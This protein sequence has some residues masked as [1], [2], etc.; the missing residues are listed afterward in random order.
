MRT[1]TRRSARQAPWCTRRATTHSYPYCWRTKTPIIYRATPQWF[2]S[3]EKQGLRADTL[4]AIRTVKWVPD[5]G[6][7]RID[8]MIAGRP[9]W[10]ISRQRYWGV[11]ICFLTHRDSG[12]LHPDT[13][14]LIERAASAIETSGIQA[15]F[16]MSV[17]DALGPDGGDPAEWEKVTDVL[18]VWFDS[19]TTWSHVLQASDRYP[20][21]MYLEGSDQHRGWF[22]SSLLTSVR[23]REARPVPTGA[24]A[25][26]HGRC[27]GAQDVEVARQRHRP[28]EAHED[29][30]ARTSSGSGC[31]RRDYR[32]EMT[33]A[34]EILDRMSD[35]LP[36]HPE[37]RP[38]PASAIG[39]FDPATDA[40]PP[41]DMLALD[42]WAVDRDAR[43]PGEI[44]TAYER[45]QFHTVY[46]T[47]HNFCAVDMAAST[48]TS[49][50]I[51][52]TRC[53]AAS[54]GQAHPPRAPCS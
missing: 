47:L 9:D 8:G 54:R 1:W 45:Y 16:D 43:R 20:A 51:A 53:R 52:S 36:A 33:V 40:V 22:H 2:V 12:E 50:R 4:E 49:S 39:D 44:E 23:D 14:T 46:Q 41:H 30:R 31:A 13:P 42:A 5:W 29:A 6:R 26:L 24:D 32:G 35:S 21:D 17:S 15:W 37:H 48:S 38:L 10:C 34:S 11:P 18:D 25:R 3:M 19:G 27:A 7:A 28:A